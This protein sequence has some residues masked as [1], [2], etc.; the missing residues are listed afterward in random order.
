MAVEG[1]G[2]RYPKAKIKWLVTIVTQK[3]RM[4]GITLDV[5]PSGVFI[6]CAIPL[7]LN[8][9]FDMMIEV[10]E[11]KRPLKAKAEVVWSNIHGPDDE[12]SPRGMGARFVEISGEDRKVI[13][14]VVME[15]YK[16]MKLEPKFMDNLQTLVVDAQKK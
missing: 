15:H 4:E 2:R 11:L 10:P 5:S 14:K 13:A 7:K 6:S 1:D 8:Q 16:A 12:I 9:V 3:G